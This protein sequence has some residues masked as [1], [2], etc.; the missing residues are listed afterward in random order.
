MPPPRVYRSIKDQFYVAAAT[1]PHPIPDARVTQVYEEVRA[2]VWQ[3]YPD[4]DPELQ[5]YLTEYYAWARLFQ[6]YSEFPG[7]N[8]YK[9]LW[10]GERVNRHVDKLSTD[11]EAK[12]YIK[13]ICDLEFKNGELRDTVS[14]SEKTIMDLRDE[15][16]QLL[17]Q[18]VEKKLEDRLSNELEIKI[19]ALKQE[20]RDAISR[21][22]DYIMA[23]RKMNGTL[24][25]EKPSQKPTTVDAGCQSQ[26]VEEFPEDNVNHDEATDSESKDTSSKHGRKDLTIPRLIEKLKK[27]MRL[28][29][30][31]DLKVQAL[32]AEIA[33]LK[34]AA[35][36]NALMNRSTTAAGS[37]GKVDE[38]TTAEESK[39]PNKRRRLE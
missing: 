39:N 22:S 19:L 18:L 23:N 13:Q 6:K 4:E 10:E 16:E 11:K 7:R 12:E 26:A 2:E 17:S 20:L 15:V 38:S 34:R 24:I 5:R 27:K 32:E 25:D 8:A 28:L 33:Q 14:E 1:R 36:H 31:R 35:S 21:K 37:E 29:V 9:S 30:D 3:E